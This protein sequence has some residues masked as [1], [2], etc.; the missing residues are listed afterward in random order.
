MQYKFFPKTRYLGS[1]RKLLQSLFEVFSAIEFDT[2]LDPFSGTGAASYLLKS[3]NKS[4]TLCDSMAFNTVCGRVLV[5]NDIPLFKD[6]ASRVLQ[7]AKKSDLCDGMVEKT[8]DGLFFFK[9]ENR[10]ID[11]CLYTIQSL[12]GLERDAALYLLGQACLIK[13][14]YNLF[15]RANLNMRS[16][17]VVRSFGNKTTWDKPFAEHMM[18][19]AEEADC[20]IFKGN[21]Q[22]RA[23]RSDVFT[24][25]PE[26]FDLV[27]L[28][29]PYVSARGAH[30]DYADYYHFL[31]GLV[32][33]LSWASRILHQY[34]HKPIDDKGKSP[35][36]DPLR[37]AEAF[38]AVIS[39]FSR[40][41][42]VI[43][44][45][46]DGIPS[47]EDI[48]RYLTKAGKTACV[49][50]AGKYTYALSTNRTSREAFIVAK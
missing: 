20:A 3:M 48:V 18:W 19:F 49:L 5:E 34:K 10:F 50:D 37:I 39:Q 7:E 26:G 9:D 15:H 33:P 14:P 17:D 45:R 42:M 35:F 40:S 16:R 1:K 24:I 30:V 21:E 27:Y 25:A 47:I 12:E 46:S 44:Y 32:D 22:C 31:E 23:Y 6:V 36:S 11:R 28:D 2:A 13:R 4:V 29:P 41:T 38:E 43:S 8:F